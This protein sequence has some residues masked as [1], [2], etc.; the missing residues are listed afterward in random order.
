MQDCFAY[1]MAHP[2]ERGN[3]IVMDYDQYEAWSENARLAR[4]DYLSGK[5]TAE[6]FLR[7]IDTMHDLESYTVAEAQSPP[8]ETVWQQMVAA[9][10]GF[11]PEAHYPKNFNAAGPKSRR[12]RMG[13]LL[14]G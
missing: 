2:N 14:G 4:I 1:T 13:D 5:L 11:D 3:L 9:D 7:K 8:I 12:T 10:V 6:T